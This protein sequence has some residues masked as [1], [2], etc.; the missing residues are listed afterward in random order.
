MMI[1]L[2]KS[3]ASIAKIFCKAFGT[4]VW[5]PS[6]PGRGDPPSG[7]SPTLKTTPPVWVPLMSNLQPKVFVSRLCCK[8]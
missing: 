7:R 3:N 2:S 5:D 8:I 4:P 6:P 1:T